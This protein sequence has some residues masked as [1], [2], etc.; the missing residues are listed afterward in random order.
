MADNEISCGALTA[1]LAV[2]YR[3]LEVVS[4]KYRSTVP[5]MEGAFIR[6][7]LMQLIAPTTPVVTGEEI[8]TDMAAP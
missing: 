5:K 1:G 6:S 7:F 4:K 2:K 3:R 8:T